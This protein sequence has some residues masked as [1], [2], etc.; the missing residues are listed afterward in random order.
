MC[1][2]AA[3]CFISGGCLDTGESW[4]KPKPLTRCAAGRDGECSHTE[5]PQLRDSEPRASGRHCPLDNE[6]TEA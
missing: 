5:C 6:R 3:A 4:S 2:S 1:R